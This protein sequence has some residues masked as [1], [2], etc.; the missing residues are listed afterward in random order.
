V[1]EHV[2]LRFEDADAARDFVRDFREESVRRR[3]ADGD[4]VAA[5]VGEHTLRQFWRRTGP[6]E[7]GEWVDHVL[8]RRGEP[9]DRWRHRTVTTLTT[10][11]DWEDGRG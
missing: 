1:A 5:L 11:M 9:M 4:V 3:R 7:E 2:V 8:F 10:S 6:G